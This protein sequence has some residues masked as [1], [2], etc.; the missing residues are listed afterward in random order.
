MQAVISSHWDKLQTQ[1]T[2][3]DWVMMVCIFNQYISCTG[4]MSV[5]VSWL[6]FSF[7]ML[8]HMCSEEIEKLRTQHTRLLGCGRARTG[9]HHR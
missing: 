3:P 5:C 9:D 4:R 6:P 8:E 7:T 1:D 2:D